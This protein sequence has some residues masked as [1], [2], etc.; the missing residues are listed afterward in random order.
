VGQYLK[1]YNSAHGILVLFRLDDKTWDTP[2]R[3]KGRPFTELVAYAQ[4]Q[5]EI[6]KGQ[7][8]GVQELIVFAI[9]CLG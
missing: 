9:D 3:A 7:S 1:G 6:I 2:G 4:E 8:K 5:A